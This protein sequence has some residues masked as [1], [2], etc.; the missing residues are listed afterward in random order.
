MWRKRH[1]PNLEG[2]N[3]AVLLF[4]VHS[5]RD[6]FEM[7]EKRLLIPFLQN[8]MF[9]LVFLLKIKTGWT[10][11]IYDLLDMLT[12]FVADVGCYRQRIFWASQLSPTNLPFK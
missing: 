2:E 11:L 6:D 8:K 4:F 10:S 7:L 3:V 5:F 9:I 1:N 12:V